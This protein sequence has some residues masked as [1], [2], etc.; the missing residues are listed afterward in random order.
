MPTEGLGMYACNRGDA[1]H[2]GK[3]ASQDVQ[4]SIRHDESWPELAEHLYD[5]GGRRDCSVRVPKPATPVSQGRDRA[6]VANHPD[7]TSIPLQRFIALI[8]SGPENQYRGTVRYRF[9]KEVVA[10]PRR[11]HQTR[12]R[13]NDAQSHTATLARREPII[14]E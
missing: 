7:L 4:L 8:R 5:G 13:I 1:E 12:E 11:T 10:K 14:A 3:H 6:G 2:T 9:Y